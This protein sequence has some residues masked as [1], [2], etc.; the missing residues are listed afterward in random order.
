[1]PLNMEALEGALQTIHNE[2][3]GEDADREPIDFSI[4]DEWSPHSVAL[5]QMHADIVERI[6]G[7]LFGGVENQAVRIYPI[8]S[9]SADVLICVMPYGIFDYQIASPYMIE[10]RKLGDPSDIRDV[11]AGVAEEIDR[12]LKFAPP[13]QGDTP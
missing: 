4:R 12:L 6:E 7:E 10:V 2:E 5:D 13:N 3:W 1:M 9:D 11:L 8:E